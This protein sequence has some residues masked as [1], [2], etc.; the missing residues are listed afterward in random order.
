VE[1][2]VQGHL[3]LHRELGDMLGYMKPCKKKKKNKNITQN[4]TT[5]AEQWWHKTLIPALRRQRQADF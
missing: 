2:R 5:Q 4:N 3:Q 1:F